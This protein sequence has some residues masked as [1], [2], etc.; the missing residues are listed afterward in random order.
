MTPAAK[1]KKMVFNFEEILVLKKKTNP[2]PKVVP[3]NI[4]RNPITTYNVALIINLV[5]FKDL[6]II[7]LKSIIYIYNI[8]IKEISISMNTKDTI[9]VIINNVI[10]VI[11]VITNIFSFLVKFF[12]I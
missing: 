7:P 12:I 6:I 11:D 3:R 8:R 5:F 10:I 4:I 9:K 2:L 1:P